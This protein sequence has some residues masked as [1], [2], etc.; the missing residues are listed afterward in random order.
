MAIFNPI[1]RFSGSS[2][3]LYLSLATSKGLKMRNYKSLLFAGL[4]GLSVQALAQDSNSVTSGKS[5][6]CR[7]E[8]GFVCLADDYITCDG[9]T[10]CAPNGMTLEITWAQGS[11]WAA[12]PGEA[13]CLAPEGAI[14]K[15]SKSDP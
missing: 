6:G 2:A 15:Q 7:I 8:G 11:P 10:V 1:L 3:I 13:S 4:L 9:K 5:S 14:W 12:F